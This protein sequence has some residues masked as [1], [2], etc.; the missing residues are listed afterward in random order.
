MFTSSKFIMGLACLAVVLVTAL[1]KVMD[2][3]VAFCVCTIS[4]GF[5]GAN[6]M[7][8]RKSME[9]DSKPTPP[10]AGDAA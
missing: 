3:N 1:C 7:I 9:P 6:A 4:G 8:T 2:A 10:P 5:M